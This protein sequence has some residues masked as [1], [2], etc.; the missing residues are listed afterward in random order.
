MLVALAAIDPQ[1]PQGAEADALVHDALD[2][3]VHAPR[4]EHAEIHAARTDGVVRCGYSTRSDPM[5]LAAEFGLA[6]DPARYREIDA[7]TARRL[8][9]IILH[10]D[11]AYDAEIMPAGRAAA[12]ADRFLSS[13][14]TEGVRYFTNGTCAEHD[15]RNWGWNRVTSATFDTGVLVVG[16]RRCGCLWVED[17]D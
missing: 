17:E 3:I 8:V 4:L 14:G 5:E 1:E 10:R 9:E 13:F 15:G 2:R 11:L 6:A 12:L 7:A 16:P